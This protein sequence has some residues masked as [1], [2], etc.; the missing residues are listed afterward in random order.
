MFNAEAVSQV[1]TNR[2][3][4]ELGMS[5]GNLHYHFQTKQQIIE[6]LFRRFAAEMAPFG[7]ADATIEA[8]DDMWLALHLAYEV[9]DRYRFVHR[10]IEYLVHEYPVMLPRA[11]AMTAGYLE[12]VRRVIRKLASRDVLLASE[13][14]V[15]ALTLQIVLNTTCWHTFAKL[16]MPPGDRAGSTGQAAYHTLT[17]LAQHV[18]LQGRAYLDYLR[19]KYRA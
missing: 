14:Q 3:A 4:T 15:E 6:A 18:S 8:I 10:D 13:D 16:A 11:R 9:I 7:A 19:E 1:S 5:P 17:L 2:L 12:G